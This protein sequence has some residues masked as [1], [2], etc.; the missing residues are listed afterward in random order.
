MARVS[1]YY[2]IKKIINT[3][4]AQFVLKGKLFFSTFNIINITFNNIDIAAF[5]K[6]ISLQ[7]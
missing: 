3:E 7:A 4:P 5:F 1:L 6:H 2:L